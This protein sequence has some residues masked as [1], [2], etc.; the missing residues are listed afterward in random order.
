LNTNRWQELTGPLIIHAK[1]K[2]ALVFF[3]KALPLPNVLILF[4]DCWKSIICCLLK[5]TIP[6]QHMYVPTTLTVVTGL[7]APNVVSTKTWNIINYF[8]DNSY[9]WSYFNLCTCSKYINNQSSWNI[10]V[11]SSNLEKFC[12]KNWHRIG[13]LQ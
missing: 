13:I 8:L 1:K 6:E 9:N 10:S 2:H 7:L 3:W 4:L 11:L 5:A 12:F